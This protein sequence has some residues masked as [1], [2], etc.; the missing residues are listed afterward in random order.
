MGKNRRSANGGGSSNNANESSNEYKE[1]TS[2]KGTKIEVREVTDAREFIKLLRE[3]KEFIDDDKK[4][5][6]DAPVGEQ[7]VLDW[8]KYHEGVKMY[9]T[10][11]GTTGAVMP[12]G[13]MIALSSGKK[14][15]GS[16]M[17]EWQIQNGGRFLDSY[18]G[19]YGLYRKLGF[20]PVSYTP[21]NADYAKGWDPNINKP[22]DVVFM[23]YGGEKAKSNL[24]R[25]ELE[26]ELK[27]WKQGHQAQ[28]D[29]VNDET[30][31][32][33]WGY[34]KAEHQRN[35][36]INDNANLHDIWKMEG[37]E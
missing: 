20:E 17:F 5:R 7:D 1:F 3:N 27:T 33:E 32:E 23:V 11:N 6:V 10:P 24:S 30:G 2:S 25:K 22:E 19:N 21:F 34:D 13:D 18:D 35:E 9:V 31:E 12:N 28:Y 16:A 26:A 4:W 36:F 14:G 37:L 8:I 29:S 15:E